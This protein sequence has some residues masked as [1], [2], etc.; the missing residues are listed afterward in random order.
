MDRSNRTTLFFHYPS[1]NI[2]KA[3][4]ERWTLFCCLS[5]CCNKQAHKAKNTTHSVSSI[6]LL[7]GQQ[8]SSWHVFCVGCLQLSQTERLAGKGGEENAGSSPTAGKGV[9]RTLQKWVTSGCL[10]GTRPLF[11]SHCEAVEDIQPQLP[12]PG[13]QGRSEGL[14]S[15]HW[16][17]LYPHCWWLDPSAAPATT[18]SDWTGSEGPS[19]CTAS[20]TLPLWSS[21]PSAGHSKWHLATKCRLKSG[22]TKDFKMYKIL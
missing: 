16:G 22:I 13:S 5:P 21:N 10:V 3:N 18:T 14:H 12:S 1:V 7:L 6:V 8:C 15:S 19:P 17:L 4:S 20:P 11:P 2:I 9:Y